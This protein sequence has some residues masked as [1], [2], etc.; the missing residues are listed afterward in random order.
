[1]KQI[2]KLKLKKRI[3]T[4]TIGLT[5]LLSL[6]P[7]STK[8]VSATELVNESCVEN[9]ALSD[10][11]YYCMVYNLN[12]ELVIDIIKNRTYD[13]GDV[14]WGTYNM[15]GYNIYENKNQGILEVIKDIHDN[16]KHYGYTK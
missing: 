1:M 16:P 3:L 12:P 7:I 5:T 9:D 6:A 4:S 13:F 14:A 15:I 8:E 10:I 11:N 2:E